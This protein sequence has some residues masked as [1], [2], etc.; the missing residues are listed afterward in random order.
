MPPG[1]KRT[2]NKRPGDEGY[3]PL[4]INLPQGFTNVMEKLGLS[5]HEINLNGFKGQ[6]IIRIR[7]IEIRLDGSF[8]PNADLSEENTHDDQEGDEQN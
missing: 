7:E 6:L 1:R 8:D 5:E 3:Q 2:I 4:T